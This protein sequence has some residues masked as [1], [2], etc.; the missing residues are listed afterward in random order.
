MFLD[1]GT[2]LHILLLGLTSIYF[3]CFIL[4]HKHFT[5]FFLLYLLSA[6]ISTLIVELLIR[7]NISLKL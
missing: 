4:I 5:L 2:W 1:D 7:I 3:Q 6:N